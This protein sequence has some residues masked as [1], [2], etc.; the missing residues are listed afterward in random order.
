MAKCQS[1]GALYL[2]LRLSPFPRPKPF[3]ASDWGLVC[4][5]CLRELKAAIQGF[6]T[7]PIYTLC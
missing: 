5:I 6:K 3:G 2:P 4:G 7:A 1:C